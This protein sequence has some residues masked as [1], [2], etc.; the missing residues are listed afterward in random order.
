ML[1]SVLNSKRAIGVNIRI[2][3]VYT[4][5]REMILT[6]KDVLLKLEQLERNDISQDEQLEI[7]FSTL[8]ELLTQPKAARKLIG[9]RRN[10]EEAN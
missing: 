8:K 10:S 4:K 1:S 5:M 7:I 2:M 6:Q 3:R 9:F